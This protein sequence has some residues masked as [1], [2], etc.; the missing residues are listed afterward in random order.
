MCN[1]VLSFIIALYK[2]S[3]RLE[4]AIPECDS[5]KFITVELS[6]FSKKLVLKK[7]E[8][9]FCNLIIFHVFPSKVGIRTRLLLLNLALNPILKCFPVHN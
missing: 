3:G 8:R 5:Q 4:L 6:E 7:K 9:K 1:F 2:F